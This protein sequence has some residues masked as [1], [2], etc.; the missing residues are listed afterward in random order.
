MA[1]WAHSV[2]FVYLVGAMDFCRIDSATDSS[3]YK[4]GVRHIKITDK[5]LEASV[6][7]PMDRN[8][9]CPYTALWFE[10]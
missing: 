3:L 1:A 7:Y 8:A 10:D 4:V 9:E 5:Q 2:H 6:Y